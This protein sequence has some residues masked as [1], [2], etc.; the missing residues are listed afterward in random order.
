M[1]NVECLFKCLLAI[2][3]SSLEKCLFRSF[4]HF[5]IQLLVVC[6]SSIELYELLVY[7]GS[8]ILL[9]HKKESI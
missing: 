7:F 2:S 5:L 8:G 4:T 9:S 3:M 6:F 1:N